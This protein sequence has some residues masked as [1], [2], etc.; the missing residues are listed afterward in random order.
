MARNGTTAEQ[1]I[2]RIRTLS[3]HE[4]T[5]PAAVAARIVNDA[6]ARARHTDN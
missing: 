6:V 5:T 2:D 3:R 4:R 1:A